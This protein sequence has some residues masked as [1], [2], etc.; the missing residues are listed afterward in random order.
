MRTGISAGRGLSLRLSL[1]LRVGLCLAWH[2]IHLASGGGPL[3]VGMMVW[4][5]RR[6]R[7]RLCGRRRRLVTLF[8]HRGIDGSSR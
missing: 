3:S 8:E 1:G 2:R 4:W 5:L 6:G 7:C